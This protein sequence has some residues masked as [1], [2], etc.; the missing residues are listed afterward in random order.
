[1][2]AAEARGKLLWSK[3]TS[4]PRRQLTRISRLFDALMEDLSRHHQPVSALFARSGSTSGD[5]YRLSE[6]QLEF[7]HENGYLKKPLSGELVNRACAG[8]ALSTQPQKLGDSV[9][10][11]NLLA[12]QEF[13][14]AMPQ[15]AELPV[16]KVIPGK[17]G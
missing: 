7:F 9:F 16:Q 10:L 4:R 8:I 13:Q 17:K 1:M 15:F 11:I 6:E 3:L 14:R 2:A 12:L 5:Q